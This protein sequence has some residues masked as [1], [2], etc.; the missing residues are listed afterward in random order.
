MSFENGP[1]NDIKTEDTPAGDNLSELQEMALKRGLELIIV[2]ENGDELALLP[3]DATK[4]EIQK[5]MQTLA[6][7]RRLDIN[8]LKVAS[9]A[10][11]PTFYNPSEN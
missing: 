3:K 10:N 7:T 1:S 9:R 11:D 4:E 8:K 5:K 2:D 6:S